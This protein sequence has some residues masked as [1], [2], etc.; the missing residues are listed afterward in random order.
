MENNEFVRLEQVIDKLFAQYN[1]LK[2]KCRSLEA[3]LKKRED[4]CET[5]MKTISVMEK[6]RAELSQRVASLI[7]KIE[8]WEVNVDGDS[9]K[10]EVLQTGIQGNLFLSEHESADGGQEPGNGDQ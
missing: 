2:A 3:N 1:D 7:R 5:F 9:R 10:K 4:E 6:E 8:E